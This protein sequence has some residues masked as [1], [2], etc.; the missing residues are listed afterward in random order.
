LAT[1]TGER[2]VEIKHRREAVNPN[3]GLSALVSD[4]ETETPEQVA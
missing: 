1:T 4:I 2:K 3:P